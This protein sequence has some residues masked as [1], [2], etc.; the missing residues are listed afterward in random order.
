MKTIRGA[1]TGSIILM[2]TLVVLVALAS[3]AGAQAPHFCNGLQATIVGTEGPDVIRGTTGADV[4]VALGGNDI[5][6]GYN[7]ADTICAGDGIDRVLGGKRGDWIDGGA[8]RDKLFGDVGDDTLHGGTGNDLL[9]GGAG[10]DTLDGGNGKRDRLY[11]RSGTAECTDNQAT[12]RYDAICRPPLVFTDGTVGAAVTLCQDYERFYSVSG[13][14]AA[15]FA[16]NRTDT[17][18][19]VEVTVTFTD[20]AGTLIDTE[21]VRM[22]VEPGVEVPWVVSTYHFDQT[23]VIAGCTATA[24]SGQFDEVDEA[25]PIFTNLE[26]DQT[27]GYRSPWQDLSSINDDH[28]NYSVDVVLPG[29]GSFSS[30]LVLLDAEGNPVGIGGWEWHNEPLNGEVRVADQFDVS[31]DF[32]W[33]S[34]QMVVT[35]R[36]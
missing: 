35:S 11:G 29:G 25:M 5:I 32:S 31:P 30:E 7:G 17:T 28:I 1:A 34:C 9:I 21:S 3:Q 18:R 26:C 19:V 20:A 27:V 10:H 12:T 33:N 36:Y 8:D 23:G 22:V 15:G 24:T 16:T 14:I 4:I 2:T 6:Y 13:P